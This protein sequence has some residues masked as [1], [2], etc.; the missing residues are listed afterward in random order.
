MAPSRT[1][2]LWSWSWWW[3]STHLPFLCN[4]PIPIVSLHCVLTVCGDDP[5]CR[6]EMLSAQEFHRVG[7]TAGH[8]AS[9][10]RM[11]STVCLVKWC[12]FSIGALEQSNPFLFRGWLSRAF[13]LEDRETCSLEGGGL[14]WGCWC[15]WLT[16]GEVFLCSPCAACV[17]SDR[18]YLPLR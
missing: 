7:R 13:V 14:G 3:C 11:Q 18:Q 6:S 4:I 16:V 17:H 2:S 8:I 15:V 9:T 1:C 10:L 5:V 12:S